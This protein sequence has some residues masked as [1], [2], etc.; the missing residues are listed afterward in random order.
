MKQKIKDFSHKKCCLNCD[1]FCWW[2]GDYCCTKEMKIHQY[3]I[4]YPYGY[5]WMN[6]D[7]ENTM[8]TPETCIE[9]NYRHHKR[10]PESD[11]E[12]IKEY[13]KFREW[14]DLIYKYESHI[15]D[16]SGVYQLLKNIGRI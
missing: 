2:D 3:G 15:Q 5:M 4:L 14:Q 9:Y 11:N 6:K 16:K 1:G 10:Y 13:R 12:Y 7:I 8:Q